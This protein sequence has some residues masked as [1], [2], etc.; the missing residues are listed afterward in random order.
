M[1]VAAGAM[2]CAHLLLDSLHSPAGS[3]GSSMHHSGGMQMDGMPM[4]AARSSGG[5]LGSLMHLAV[6]VVVLQVCSMAVVLLIRYR[7]H[8]ADRAVFPA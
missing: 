2:V 7:R 5:L 1:L 4:D 8:T 6:A 3:D